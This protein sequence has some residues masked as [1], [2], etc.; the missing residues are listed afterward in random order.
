VFIA[1]LVV[2]TVRAQGLYGSL[3]GNVTDPTTASV[4]G[5]KVEITHVQTNQVRE[6]QSNTDGSYTF[7]TIPPGA[8]EI[9]ISTRRLPDLH[10]TKHPRHIN[11]TVRVDA[12]LVVGSAAQSVEV[13]GQTALL[14]TEAAEVRSQ[15]TTNSLSNLP[16]PLGRNYESLYTTIPGFTPQLPRSASHLQAV[17]IGVC[18]GSRF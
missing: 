3:A 1:P 17:I 9:E 16:L 12:S 4:L 15:F 7:P 18:H 2:Q 8:S 6:T 5:A 13:T 14:Q 10:T 11:T